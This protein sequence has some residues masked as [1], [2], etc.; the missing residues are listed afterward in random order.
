MT[1]ELRVPAVGESIQEVQIGRWLKQ[2]GDTVD[3]D[4][5]VVELETDKATME[6]PAPAAGVL[7]EIVKREGDAVAVGDVIAY[8]DEGQKKSDTKRTSSQASSS[9]PKEGKVDAKPAKDAA[10]A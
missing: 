5:N 3:A 9:E 10:P 8:L 6:V 2:Q 1:I 4:E 7:S